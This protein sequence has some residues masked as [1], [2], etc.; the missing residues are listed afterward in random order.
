MSATGISRFTGKF[1]ESETRQSMQEGTLKSITLR[2]GAQRSNSSAQ[3]ERVERGT[4][5]KCGP[6]LF[7]HSFRYASNAIV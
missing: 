2:E 3:F 7:L 6:A 1:G 4:I 5:I